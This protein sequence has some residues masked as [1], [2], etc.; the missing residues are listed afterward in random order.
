MSLA[1]S[2]SYL[3]SNRVTARPK[4][5]AK[6]F[7]EDDRQRPNALS[8]HSPDEMLFTRLNRQEENEYQKSVEDSAMTLW[9]EKEDSR[10]IYEAFT[11]GWTNEKA[12]S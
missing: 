10:D 8:N 9:K 5:G 11:Q 7:P 4:I 6:I 1:V 2:H 3:E 12:M